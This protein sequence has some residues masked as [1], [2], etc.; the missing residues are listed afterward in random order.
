[1]RMLLQH[2]LGRRNERYLESNNFI[3][4]EVLVSVWE[5]QKVDPKTGGERIYIR[6][7]FEIGKVSLS[8]KQK[9]SRGNTVLYWDLKQKILHLILWFSSFT[10]NCIWK[11]AE[12]IRLLLTLHYS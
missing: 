1:M 3:V 2:R 6:I 4:N 5:V 9:I 11:D 10:F 12:E 7:V 8:Q